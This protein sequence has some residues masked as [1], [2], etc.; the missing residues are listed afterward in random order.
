MK[1]EL[2]FAYPAGIETELLAVA[3]VDAQTSKAPGSKP[4]PILLT[5][6]EAI[7]SAAAGVS[8]RGAWWARV[9]LPDV[10]E[11]S[12]ARQACLARLALERR[13]CRT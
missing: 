13:G 12:S 2:S 5:T 3:A 9:A 1:T 11:P 6:D 10:E 7:L 4:E 8:S